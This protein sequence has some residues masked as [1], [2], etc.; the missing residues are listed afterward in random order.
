MRREE[1]YGFALWEISYRNYP[2]G[3]TDVVVHGDGWGLVTGELT[4]CPVSQYQIS[5]QI[6]RSS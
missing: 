5:I 6:S 1:C 4:A 3:R 2:M